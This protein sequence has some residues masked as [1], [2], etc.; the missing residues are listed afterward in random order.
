MPAVTTTRRVLLTPDDIHNLAA[1]TVGFY[2]CMVWLGAVL[3]L[4]WSEV[5]GL[6]V[7]AVDMLQRKLTVTE[8]ITR[9]G[10][11]RPVVGTPKSTAGVRIIAMPQ[12]LVDI[13]AEHLA[14]RG[15]TA[16]DADCLLFEAPQGGPLRYSNWRRRV[17]LPATVAAG[18]PGAGFHD[19]RRASATALIVG[20]VNVRTAQAR[21]GH[22]DPRLTL[23][24]YAQV[25]EEADRQAAETV[26]SH[27]LSTRPRDE[28]AM[29]PRQTRS[30]E[31][32][33]P[34]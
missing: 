15:L 9:D 27:F 28:R 24:L 12:A 6:R 5:A 21:L 34:R 4:R 3:G 1:A 14:M 32:R 22:S 7:G 17:W 30:S 20:G 2:R 31:G 8:A 26:G 23:S 16:A 33:N 11:G 10:Q 13:L 25:V 19:L 29:D 18:C